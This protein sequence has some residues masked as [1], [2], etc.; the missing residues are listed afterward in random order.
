[1]TSDAPAIWHAAEELGPADDVVRFDPWIDDLDYRGGGQEYADLV[2]EFRRFMNALAAST[3]PAEEMRQVS[4]GLARLR[5]TLERHRSGRGAGYSGNRYD[6]AGRGH[7]HL[8]PAHVTRWATNELQATV[9]FGAAHIGSNDA[10]H[11]GMHPLLFDEVLG[12]LANT[13]RR[14]RCRTAYLKTDYHSV[15]LPDVAYELH[16]T[17]DEE[18]GRKRLLSARLTGP[19]GVLTA[20]AEGLFV[21]LREG[22]P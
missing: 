14:T 11:G 6:L 22:A 12:R 20:S 5:S 10:V 3:P 13:N 16:A 7:P 8:I 21:A 15:T 19:D 1:M 2:A 9:V 4:S 17:V 18:A